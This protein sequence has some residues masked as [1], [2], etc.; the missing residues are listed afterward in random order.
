MASWKT[1][2]E[3]AS[4]VYKETVTP[5]HAQ[6]WTIFF[7]RFRDPCAVPLAGL[8]AKTGLNHRQNN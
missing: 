1:A 6:R 3:A 7:W 2:P 5:R 4:E 8:A